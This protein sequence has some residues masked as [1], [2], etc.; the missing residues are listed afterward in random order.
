MMMTDDDEETIWS[1][2]MPII[3]NRFTDYKRTARSEFLKHLIAFF[4]SVGW[5][6]E[7]W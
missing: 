3:T 6:D 4:F 2:Q 5:P 1:T 7:Q